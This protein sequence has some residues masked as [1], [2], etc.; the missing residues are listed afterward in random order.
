MLLGPSH[1]MP[2]IQHVENTPRGCLT[3]WGQ[4]SHIC[5]SNQIIIGSDNSLLLCQRQAIIWTKAGILLIEPSATNFSEILIKFKHFHSRKCIWRCCHWN[6]NVWTSI[7]IIEK[8]VPN[9]PINNILALVQIMAWCRAGNNPLSEPMMLSLP[10]HICITQPCWCKETLILGRKNAETIQMR[11]A[12]LYH[13][14]L[15][16]SNH[17]WNLNYISIKSNLFDF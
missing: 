16:Y 3:L 4:V 5:V 17:I 9:G 11:V 10:M 6:G 13:A 12:Y 14:S 7:K 15:F 2:V 8:F 1:C